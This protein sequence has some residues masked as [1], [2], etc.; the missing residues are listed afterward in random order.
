[1]ERERERERNKS[2][3]D[4]QNYSDTDTSTSRLCVFTHANF[5]SATRCLIKDVT[6]CRTKANR[7]RLGI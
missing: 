7:Q 1:M 2:H 3:T 5:P 6:N 4:T